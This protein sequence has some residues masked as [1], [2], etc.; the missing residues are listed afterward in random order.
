[1]TKS[2]TTDNIDN[3][4]ENIDFTMT[5]EDMPLSTEEK[6]EMKNCLNG[7]FNLEEIIKKTIKKYKNKFSNE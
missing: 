4:I 1:M 5:M 2:F 3:I 6:E 7:T